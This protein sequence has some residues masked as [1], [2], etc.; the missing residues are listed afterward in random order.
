ME[1]REIT[2]KEILKDE[3]GMVFSVFVSG[4][5]HKSVHTVSLTRDTHDRLGDANSPEDLV[6]RSFVFL[7]ERESKDAIL[8]SFDVSD[9]SKQFPEFEE[10]IVRRLNMSDDL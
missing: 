1:M 5:G 10:E 2:V 7:L 3:E 9:I 8:E 6:K 4:E